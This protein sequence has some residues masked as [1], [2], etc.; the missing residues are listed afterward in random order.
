MTDRR[1]SV[2]PT[3]TFRWRS[4]SMASEDQEHLER[5]QRIFSSAFRTASVATSHLRRMTKMFSI[6]KTREAIRTALEDSD[7][8]EYVRLACEHE[9]LTKEVKQLRGFVVELGE[10][11][12]AARSLDPLRRYKRMQSMAKTIVLQ[13]RV[14]DP[15]AASSAACSAASDSGYETFDPSAIGTSGLIV[16]DVLQSSVKQKEMKLKHEKIARALSSEQLQRDITK[17]HSE[18]KELRCRVD[19]ITEA[20]NNIDVMYN[21]TKTEPFVKRYAILKEV[22]K[23]VQKFADDNADHIW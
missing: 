17:F 23:E 15:T 22:I 21:S 3:T 10:R 11:Y 14:N 8:G 4:R 18:N 20:I 1:Q 2:A 16:G 12:E 6:D 19:A 9:E 5:E 7:H 13:L